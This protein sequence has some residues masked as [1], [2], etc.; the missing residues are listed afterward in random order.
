M[1]SAPVIKTKVRATTT[2]STKQKMDVP[3]GRL[4]RFPRIGTEQHL[5]PALGTTYRIA[6]EFDGYA[7]FDDVPVW[8]GASLA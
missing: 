4:I 6:Y 1:R 2:T 7:L 3:S 5:H 8:P